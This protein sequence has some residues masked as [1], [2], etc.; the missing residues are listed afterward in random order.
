M[1]KCKSKSP[2]GVEGREGNPGRKHASNLEVKVTEGVTM[3][4]G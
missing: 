1:A 2:R 4:Q 3:S